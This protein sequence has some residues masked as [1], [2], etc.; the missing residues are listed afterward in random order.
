MEG[1]YGVKDNYYRIAKFNLT[2][3]ELFAI[4]PGFRRKSCNQASH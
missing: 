3:E 1:T 4:N 2:Q